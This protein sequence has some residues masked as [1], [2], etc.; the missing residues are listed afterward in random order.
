MKVGKLM[1]NEISDRYWR[2]LK[3]GAEKRDIDFSLTPT[4]A[5]KIFL[6]QNR[7]CAMTGTDLDFKS[8]GHRGTASLDRIDSQK[9]YV[10]HNVQ[11]VLTTV[12]LMK[13]SLKEDYFKLLCSQISAKNN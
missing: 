10:S 3:D 7:C 11:W 2:D 8:Y 5:W 1:K 12:N 6:T 4:E 13:G 9:S